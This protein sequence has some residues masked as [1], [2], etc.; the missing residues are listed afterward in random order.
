MS[1]YLAAWAIL[2]NN[3]G[4]LSNNDNDTQVLTYR[5]ISIEKKVFQQLI[6]V[7]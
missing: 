7:R 1:T 4:K 3:Y 2:P 5:L 6:S